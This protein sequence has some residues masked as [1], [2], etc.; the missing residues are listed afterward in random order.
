MTKNVAWFDVSSFEKNFFEGK[1]TDLTI[2]FFEEPLNE[3]TVDLV[4]GFDAVS[5]F[6]DSDVNKNVLR[7]MDV[8][9]IACRSTGF[10][11]VDLETAEELEITV[12]NVPEYSSNTV[13]EHTFALILSI[14][15]KIYDAINKV[16]EGSF[17]HE[18]LRGFDLKEKTLGIIGTGSIG[19]NVIRM[20]NGFQMNVLAYDP[21]PNHEESK[22][23]GFEYVELDELL[24]NSDI[25]SL[26]CPLNRHTEHMIS[27]EEFDIMD[28]VVLINTSRGGL[29]D[30]ESLIKALD[31]GSVEFAGLDV[32]EDECGLSDDIDYLGEMEE[33]CDLQTILHDHI[34]IKR[35]DVV[36]TPHNGFNSDEA[37]TR[38]VETTIDNLKQEKNPVHL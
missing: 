14:S 4:K 15:R 2:N 36:I 1:K 18:G 10:D 22:E 32:L 3:N 23:L 33:K 27:K 35:E 19:L 30:T 13:A 20:A 25:V 26:H 12:C 24:R 16:K 5:V 37:I 34:L 8:D 38:L 7:E 31:D 9:I 21:Y 29:V 11:H 17:D 6:I 28:K